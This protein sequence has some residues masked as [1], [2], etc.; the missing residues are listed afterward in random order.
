MTKRLFV[1]FVTIIVSGFVKAQVFLYESFEETSFPPTGW[2]IINSG[3]G[4]NWIQNTTSTYASSGSKSMMYAFTSSAPAATWA[5]TPAIQLDSADSVII[6]FDQRVGLA[7]YAEAMKLTVGNAQNVAS[8]TA[9][10]YNDN[11]LT[12]TSFLQRSAT[13]IAAASGIYYFA[14]NC[15]S[16]ADRYK[17]Y[18]DNIRIEKPMA[19]NAGLVSLTIPE[20]GCSFDSLE[21]IDIGIKNTGTDTI[22]NFQVNYSINGSVAITETISSAIA[23]ETTLSYT[24]TTQA[25]LTAPGIYTIKAYTS[26][27]GD[28]DPYN[29]TL[30]ETTEHIEGGVFIKSSVEEVIIPD[31]STS[32]A[33]SSISFCGLPAVMDGTTVGIDYLKI[34]SINH[35]WISDLTIYLLS[36]A[37][38]NLMISA[39]NGGGG[40]N[41][42]NVTFIDTAATNVGSISTNG[43]SSGYYHIES[44]AGLA[45]FNTGQNPNGTWKLKVVDNAT[46][47]F[48]KICRWTLA[49]KGATA[50]NED[51]V[52]ESSLSVYPNPTDENITI[53]FK[54]H[55]GTLNI[56]LLNSSGQLIYNDVVKRQGG[57]ISELSLKKY[58]KGIYFLQAVTENRVLTKKIVVY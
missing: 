6:T 14:F 51:S 49:F 52:G 23:P 19:K 30:T 42:V 15:Y 54:D 58:G 20:S 37:N 27:S 34:D 16:P 5:F 43:I 28:G 45:A 57:Y 8:Q 33:Y 48:G 25:D 32:G 53:Y 40:T 18:I 1:L 24:F 22:S 26:L 35:S 39:G 56:K 17:L 55:T 47:D 9:I 12:N 29:D 10:L 38:D 31:N 13:Y 4:N 21:T 36:P 44:T 46:G 2:T 50:I 7:I 3:A 41:I 11:N